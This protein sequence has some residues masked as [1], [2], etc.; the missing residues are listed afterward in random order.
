VSGCDL[1]QVQKG[2]L[3]DCNSISKNTSCLVVLRTRT[4]AVAKEA[5]NRRLAILRGDAEL[6]R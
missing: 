2:L 5:D 4:A 3:C 6:R 1:A